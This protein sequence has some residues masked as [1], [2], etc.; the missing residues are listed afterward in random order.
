MHPYIFWVNK[1]ILNSSDVYIS[2]Q[3]PIITSIN[4]DIENIRK[5]KEEKNDQTG[6]LPRPNCLADWSEL[7]RYFCH[8][9]LLLMKSVVIFVV[10]E[11]LSRKK[12]LFLVLCMHVLMHI[13][14]YVLL[15]F[16]PTL[17]SVYPNYSNIQAW[18]NSGDPDQMPQN[19]ASDLGLH[20]NS[21]SSV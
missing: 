7:L 17:F 3:V 21:P 11:I 15:H 9:I 2:Y 6:T 4:F 19:V 13:Y 12:S 14:I 18:A 10:V 16:L 5:I 20:C 8:K 1:F